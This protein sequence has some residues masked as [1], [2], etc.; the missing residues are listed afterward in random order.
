[1]RRRE[2]ITLLGGAAIW[3]LAARAQQRAVPVVGFLGNSTPGPG[4]HLLAALRQGLSETG[5]VEG[6]NLTIEYRWAEG[7]YDR[8]PTMAADLVDGKVDVIVA[9]GPPAAHAAKSATPTIPIVFTTADAVGDGL[10]ANLPRPGGNLTGVSLLNT[11]LDAKRFE[12]LSELVPQAKVIVLLVNPNNP[13]TEH[14]ASAVQEAARAKGIQLHILKASTEGEIDAAFATLVQRQA[15][16]LDVSYEPF[17]YNQREQITALTARH[18]VPAISGFREFATAGGLISYGFN[19]TAVFRQV[20]ICAG[21]ILKGANPAD[22]P[23]EQPTK[24]EL[25]INMKTAKTLG[26]TIPSSILARADEVIE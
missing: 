17:F 25:V 7:H 22:I 18:A 21:K 14:I 19:N 5:Y 6:Q 1:M 12:L 11:E 24:F 4:A 9:I 2:T 3:P 13:P 16:A 15:G 10:V 23:V 26:L 8:L 20:G